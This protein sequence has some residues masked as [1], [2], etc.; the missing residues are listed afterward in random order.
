VV[1][2][3]GSDEAV[4]AV[5]ELHERLRAFRELMTTGTPPAY[6]SDEY[7]RAYEP[8][9]LARDRFVEVARAELG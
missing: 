9:V 5:Q 8:V 6:R 3:V 1:E 7:N 4:A 2:L